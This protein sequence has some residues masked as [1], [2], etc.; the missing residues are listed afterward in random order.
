MKKLREKLSQGVVM[1]HYIPGF[2]I[3]EPTQ[4]PVRRCWQPQNG[5]LRNSGSAA[6]GRDSDTDGRP[7]Y[8]SGNCG[9]QLSFRPAI[10]AIVP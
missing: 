3:Y 10:Q 1:Q 7:A 4:F 6:C 2:S 9:W 5:R 8:H